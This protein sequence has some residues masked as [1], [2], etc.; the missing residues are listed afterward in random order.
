VAVSAATVDRS[1]AAGRWVLV[2]LTLVALAIHFWGLYRPVGPPALWF[3]QAD[4]V[5]HALGFAAPLLLILLSRRSFLRARNR[6]VSRVFVAGVTALFVVHGVVSELFQY[7]L[8]P[9][10][11]GDPLDVAADWTGCALGVGCFLLLDRRSAR[12]TSR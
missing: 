1:G 12:R 3:P 10:R 7:A 9:G 8:L 4:K 6:T 2:A 5:E 11:S